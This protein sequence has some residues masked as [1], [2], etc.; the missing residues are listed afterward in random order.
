MIIFKLI[1]IGIKQNLEC[2]KFY[3]RGQNKTKKLKYFTYNFWFLARSE[4]SFEPLRLV[5]EPPLK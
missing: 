4:G 1:S 5:V 2:S 3:F